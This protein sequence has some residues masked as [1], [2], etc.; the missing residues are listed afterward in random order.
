MIKN[1]YIGFDLDEDNINNIEDLKELIY[2]ILIETPINTRNMSLIITD[3][4]I[5]M[6]KKHHIK[7]IKE[8]QEKATHQIYITDLNNTNNNFSLLTIGGI[9]LHLKIKEN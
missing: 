2:Q 9:K 1:F 4:V 7:L 3:F 8:L 5:H 6:S